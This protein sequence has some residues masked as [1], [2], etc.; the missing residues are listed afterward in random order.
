MS[1]HALQGAL[2]IAFHDEG[3]V[4][5][6][7]RDPEG[8]L[9][10]MRLTP[11]ERAQLLAVDPR[12]FRTDPLRRRRILRVLAEELRASTTLALAETRSL[13]FAEGF[14]ASAH[15]RAAVMERRALVLAFGD[16]LAAAGLA[17]PLGADIIRLETLLARCRRDRLRAPARGVALAPG[18]AVAT[19]DAATLPAVQALERYVFELGLMPQAALCDDRPPPPV[20]S[21][22]GQ[23]SHLLVTPGGSGVALT[24]IDADLHRVLARLETPIDRKDA[25][26]ALAPAGVPAAAAADLVQSLLEDGLLAEG[27]PAGAE[28]IA[29]RTA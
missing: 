3:F 14:F 2:V 20:A 13:A 19:F 6:M 12:A 29:T 26:A 27:W 4:A 8:T 5:A 24:A 28:L 7:R 25:A 21:P 11:A 18:V 10:P 16:Y 1:H 23:I 9:G 17:A 22:S 15:F